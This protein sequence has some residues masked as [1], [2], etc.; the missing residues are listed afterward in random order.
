MNIEWRVKM[1]NTAIIVIFSAI[2]GAAI[3]VCAKV[4][5]LF[6]VLV[7]AGCVALFFALWIVSYIA[8]WIYVEVSEFVRE[9]FGS[10]IIDHN[11][12]IE[13]DERDQSYIN[14]VHFIR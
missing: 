9:M 11:L 7:I 13:D 12:S 6:G 1:E 10:D 14:P 2:A 3:M 5:G 4:I 8:L